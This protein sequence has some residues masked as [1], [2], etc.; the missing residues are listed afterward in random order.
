MAYDQVKDRIIDAAGR[1]APLSFSRR[2]SKGG[3]VTG[4]L[5]AAMESAS[6]LRGE[7]RIAVAIFVRWPN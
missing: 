1:G 2:P 7:Y 3:I 4:W 6:L 5:D